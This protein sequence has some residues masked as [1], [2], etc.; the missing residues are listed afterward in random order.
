MSKVFLTHEWAPVGTREFCYAR[1]IGD[2]NHLHQARTLHA[3]FLREAR[4]RAPLGVL[5]LPD[6]FFFHEHV[7]WCE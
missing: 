1:G 3:R 7:H 4:H 5:V 2:S 6:I